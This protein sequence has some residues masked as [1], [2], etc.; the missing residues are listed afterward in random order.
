MLDNT[1]AFFNNI[2]N[3][4]GNKFSTSGFAN[5][6]GTFLLNNTQFNNGLVTTI[7]NNLMTNDTFNKGFI[8]T[9]G[10]NLISNSTFINNLASTLSNTQNSY[11]TSLVGPVGTVSDSKSIYNSLAPFTLN[12]TTGNNGM[13]CSTTYNTKGPV[14]YDLGPTTGSFNTTY[15]FGKNAVLQL[16]DWELS[17]GTNGNL[18]FKNQKD[19]SRG[20]DIANMN[21][22]NATV[23]NMSGVNSNLNL[24]N[25]NLNVQNGN[26]GAN[27]VNANNVNANNVNANWLVGNNASLFGGVLTHNNGSSPGNQGYR[28]GPFH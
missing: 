23:G 6:V 4:I 20:M 28:L 21:V 13:L 8:N 12:C 7:G 9:I 26:I 10:N 11:Y 1:G 2:A 19:S 15:N 27:N 24:N 3:T 18:Q 22:P 17:Q 14:V 5:T 16:G 25:S